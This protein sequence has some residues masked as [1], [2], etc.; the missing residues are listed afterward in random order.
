M[1][2]IASL[3]AYRRR[4]FPPRDFQIDPVMTVHVALDGLLKALD[5]L[6]QTSATPE[7]AQ[8]AIPAERARLLQGIDFI[9]EGIDPASGTLASGLLLVLLGDLRQRLIA[10]LDEGK[11]DFPNESRILRQLQ[12]VFLGLSGAGRAHG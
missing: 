6:A 1:D 9:F 12:D 8:R 3:A 11:T 10:G 7:T 5:R 4:R 2:G